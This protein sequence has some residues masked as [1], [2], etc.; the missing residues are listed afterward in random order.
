[1]FAYCGNNP[2]VRQDSSGHSWRGFWKSVKSWLTKKKEKASNN[3]N[4]TLTIGR[5]VSAALGIAGSASGGLCLDRKGNMGLTATVNV[6]AGFPS[7]SVG[8]SVTATTAPSIYH[9]KGHGVVVGASGGPGVV[10]IGG[11]YTGII[12]KE[13]EKMYHGGAISATA[14]LYPTIV[15]IHG[16]Y[17]YTWVSGVNLYDVAIDIADF[18]GGLF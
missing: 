15:E 18:M 2:I 12:D 1:M 11:E 14:G 6:G 8:G 4:G 3:G 17:G 7:A 5:T 10:A 16:E 9:L 13:N